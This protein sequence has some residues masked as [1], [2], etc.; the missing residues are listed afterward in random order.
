MDNKQ[1]III[2]KSTTNSS[3]F[4]KSFIDKNNKNFMII[5]DPINEY[6]N[7]KSQ[8]IKNMFLQGRNKPMVIV[9]IKQNK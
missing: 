1:I 2:K 4:F 3:S 5:E 9:P 6:E 8:S 7:S